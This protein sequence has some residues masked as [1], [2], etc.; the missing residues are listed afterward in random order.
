MCGI[1]GAVKLGGLPAEWDQ[2]IDRMEKALIHRGPDDRGIANFPNAI[3]G[4]RRL[5][6]IDVSGGQQP[7]SSA[8]KKISLVCNGE[9]YN[10]QELRK[11]LEHSG[12]KFRSHSDVETILHGY[13]RFGLDIT[14]LLEGMFAFAIWD[15][16]EQ[17][18][19]LARDRFG[20]KP[21]YYFQYQDKL[22]FA[23][24]L[25][26]LLASGE[27]PLDLDLNAV[28]QYLA[29]NYTPTPRSIISNIKKLEPGTMLIF[30]A[31]GI[32]TKSYSSLS[33]QQSESRPP[34]DPREVET[35]F[36]ERF[37]GAVRRELASDVPIG[38]LLSGGLDSSTIAAI[39]SRERPGISTFSVKFEDPTF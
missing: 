34:L 3:I 14:S 28:N 33:F 35:Q 31:K 29:F 36:L 22:I 12:F 18:L 6:I 17:R 25:R 8:D 19:I 39:A 7:F 13:K 2:K 26:A 20:I 9:I 16:L 5:S 11:S 32:T 37:S 10:Y 1:F 27:M 4:M 15:D 38:V 23:S 30:D 24:E 21:L